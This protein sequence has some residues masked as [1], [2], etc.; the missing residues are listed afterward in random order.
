MVVVETLAA[1]AVR[2]AVDADGS[3]Q[4]IGDKDGTLYMLMLSHVNGQ[5]RRAALLC[6]RV[7]GSPP[8]APAI[9][10]Q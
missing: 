10:R 6:R 9:A 2:F 1:G 4:L 3:R 7:R 5:V 8:A